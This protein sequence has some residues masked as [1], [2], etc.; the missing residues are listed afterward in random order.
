MDTKAKVLDIAMNLNR[1]GNWAADG[2]IKKEKR[3][4]TFVNET[5][6]LIKT[7]QESTLPNNFEKTFKLFLVQYEKLKKQTHPYPKDELGWAELMM[8]WGNIL[9]HRSQLI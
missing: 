7:V 4:A 2:Y 3:I 1:I 6:A 5:S 8:T 9:T